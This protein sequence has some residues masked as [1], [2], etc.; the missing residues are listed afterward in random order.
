M[1]HVDTLTIADEQALLAIPGI[2]PAK[3]KRYGAPFLKLVK[4]AADFY[5]TAVATEGDR[6]RD[7]NHE[8]VHVVISDSEGSYQEKGE[9]EDDEF[10]DFPDLD[11]EGSLGRSS[12]FP[13][14]EVVLFNAQSQPPGPRLRSSS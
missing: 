7:P 3:V 13:T 14:P 10:G 12:Y 1:L 8:E 2:D 5:A 4:N 11:E 9:D 6:P